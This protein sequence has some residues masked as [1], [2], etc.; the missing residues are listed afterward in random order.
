MLEIQCVEGDTIQPTSLPCPAQGWRLLPP[1][2]WLKWW[3]NKTSEVSREATTNTECRNSSLV[4]RSK[5]LV[6]WGGTKVVI[7]E[8]LR[9]RK[10]EALVVVRCV[11]MCRGKGLSGY[12]PRSSSLLAALDASQYSN[13]KPLWP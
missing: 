7:R 3:F 11:G 13:S 10:D 6:L 9:R 1:L 2:C 5:C 4:K 8:E 12:G